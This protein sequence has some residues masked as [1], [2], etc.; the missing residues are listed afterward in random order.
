M[1]I[2]LLASNCKLYSNKRIMEELQNSSH[3]AQFINVGKCYLEIS[4]HQPKIFYE[5]QNIAH[6]FQC[7]ITRIK[8][9]L[10]SYSLAIIRQFELLKIACINNST[11]I[12]NSRDKLNSLQLLAQNNLSIPT[13]SFANS[14]YDT[15]HLIELVNKAPLIIKLIEGTKG[16]GVMLAETNNAAKSIINAFR[17]VK[18]NILVQNYIKESSGEDIRCFVI[19]NKVVAAIKRKSQGEEFR[20]NIHLGAMASN[21]KISDDE[22]EMAIKA[23]KIMNL[24][25]AGVDIVRAKT[26]P[27]IIE[28]NSS[29]GLEAIEKTTN[30]NIASLI[31]KHC[32]N[33]IENGQFANFNTA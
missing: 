12:S 10:T 18:V 9:A 14:S 28:V 31:V 22:E 7:I 33:L 13:T 25:I 26:G 20:A 6:N 30:V 17:S 24:E 32:E 23:T 11:A 1:K 8:P 3:H 27:K 29:P 15:T 4:N 21:I 16:V 5:K 19:G 2:A